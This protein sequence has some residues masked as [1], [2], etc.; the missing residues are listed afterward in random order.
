EE[1]VRQ[2]KKIDPHHPVTIGWSSVNAAMNLEEQ[3]DFISYHYYDSPELFEPALYVL[4][5]K[6]KDKPIMISEFG[7]SSY[8]GLWNVFKGSEE[9]QADYYS[10]MVSQFEKGQISFLSWTLYDFE[11]IPVDVVGRLPW[12]RAPQKRYGLMGSDGRIKP[13]YEF[14]EVTSAK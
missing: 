8:S 6:L 2:V 5:S 3:L 11:D 1:K 10:Q 14:M 7:L 12:R 9:K 4:R 13:A